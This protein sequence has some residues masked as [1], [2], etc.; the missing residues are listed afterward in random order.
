[1]K[2]WG[3]KNSINVQKVLWC[4]EELGLSPQRIPAGGEF[5]STD[6]PKYVTINPNRL[7]PTLEDDDFLLWESNVIVRYLAQ[8][9]GLNLLCSSDAHES[10]DGERWMDWQATNTAAPEVVK[11]AN[12]TAARATQWV[13]NQ[14]PVPVSQKWEYSR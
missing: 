5:G 4:C 2:V 3:R 10:F 12:L 7:V 8:R 11:M 14:S 9:Y 6:D 13:S 1:M